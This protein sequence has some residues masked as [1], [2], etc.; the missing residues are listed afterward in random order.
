EPAPEVTGRMIFE[1][2]SARPAD[3][4]TVLPFARPIG[5]SG[6]LLGLGRRADADGTFALTFVPGTYRIFGLANRGWAGLTGSTWWLKSFV[7]NG[8]DVADLPFEIRSGGLSD[9]VVTLTDKRS[10]LS[11]TFQDGSGRPATDFALVVFPV[12]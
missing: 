5:S 10:D 12:E 4:T 8:V 11:G 6:S 1:G 9:V 2:T 7:V 3:L